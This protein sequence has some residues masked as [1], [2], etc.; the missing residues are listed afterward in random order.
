VTALLLLALACA[1]P[2][3]SA[4]PPPEPEPEPVQTAA[5]TESVHVRIPFGKPR[6]VEGLRGT[7]TLVAGSKDTV[8]DEQG[9][10][11]HHVTTGTLRFERGEQSDEIAF[12]SG[13]AFEHW[14]HPMAVYGM[15]ALELVVAPVGQR[16][17][18]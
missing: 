16:P 8:M 3:S 5:L 15:D 13:Q 17:K 2:E 10:F 14:G 7:V 4:A 9:R 11:S 1:G 6:T 18:P 12:T